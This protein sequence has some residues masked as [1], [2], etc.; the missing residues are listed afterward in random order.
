MA[1]YVKGYITC[2]HRDC[3]KQEDV[4]F[5]VDGFDGGET[6]LYIQKL[7]KGWLQK[8]SFW[9]LLEEVFLCPEHK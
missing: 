3:H 5:M 1:A 2:D 6:H 8:K 7:P 4:T 9:F